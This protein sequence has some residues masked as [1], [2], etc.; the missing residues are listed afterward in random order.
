VTGAGH[1]GSKIMAR[2]Q[3]VTRVGRV[4]SG[5]FGRVSSYNIRFESGWVGLFFEF[6]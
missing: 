2:A 5:R 3:P 4:G 1:V 6:G